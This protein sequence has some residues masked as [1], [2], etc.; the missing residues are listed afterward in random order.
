MNCSPIIDGNFVYASWDL[1]NF[2]STKLG[3]VVCL[4][5]AQD[6]ED[7]SP[8][9]VWRAGRH[10]G[11]LPLL[12]ALGWRALR[13]RPT[14]PSSTRSMPR[15]AKILWHKGYGTH[16]QGLAGLRR[17]QALL[18][19]SQRADV[20]PQ[21]QR[22]RTSP[23]SSATSTSRRSSAASTRSSDRS[24][25]PTATSSCRPPTRCTASGRRNRRSNP[26]RFRRCA[27]GRPR[28]I[29]D[30]RAGDASGAAG[31]CRAAPGQKQTFTVSAFDARAGRWAKRRPRSG[32]S[33][34]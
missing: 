19:R 12:D 10:R 9:V 21:A 30:S 33:A 8:K 11:R 27:A 20:D 28:S 31:G 22:R 23:K 34:S 25:S 6:R 18:P 2:D 15:P 32:R 5:G 14:A 29:G 1:D 26:I 4:D 24:R 13:R 7:G 3:G 17:R 16:R